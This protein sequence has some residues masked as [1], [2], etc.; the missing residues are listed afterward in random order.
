ME[1]AAVSILASLFVGGCA[2]TY[3]PADG[4]VDHV[5]LAADLEA[6]E[7]QASEANPLDGAVIGF[8]G[9]AA[10]GALHGATVGAMAGNTAEGAVIGTSAG[11]LLGTVYGATMG[12]QEEQ[13]LLDACMLGKGYEAS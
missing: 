5:K 13:R 9:G 4:V 12:N 3:T 11:A 2:A 1:R 10:W 6:C 8:L 7:E